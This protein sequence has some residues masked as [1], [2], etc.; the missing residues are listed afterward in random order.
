[1]IGDKIK[2]LEERIETLEKDR[3][4]VTNILDEI[5]EIFVYMEALRKMEESSRKIEL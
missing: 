5:S 3:I 4:L 2:E 1:M